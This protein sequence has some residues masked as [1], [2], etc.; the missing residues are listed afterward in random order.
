MSPVAG[1]SIAHRYQ[2]SNDNDITSKLAYNAHQTQHEDVIHSREMQ[3]HYHRRGS[4]DSSSS[5]LTSS[6]CCSNPSCSSNHDQLKLMC[7][8]WHQIKKIETNE[9]VLARRQK[10]IDYGKKTT[11]YEL[12]RKQVPM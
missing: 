12:Y 3:M 6:S 4:V 8:R 7:Q 10:Q 2:M 11:C 9:E 5:M 1:R